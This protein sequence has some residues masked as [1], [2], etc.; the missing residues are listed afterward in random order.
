LLRQWKRK[1]FIARRLIR[2]GVRP[3][4]A[5]RGVYQGKRSWWA[6]SHSPAVER[7]LPNAYFAE[8]GLVSLLVRWREHYRQNVIGPA[9][10]ELV[11]G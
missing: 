3:K 8:G 10:M 11:L 2:L 9:Q 1:R 6:L 4:T 5:W 7:G